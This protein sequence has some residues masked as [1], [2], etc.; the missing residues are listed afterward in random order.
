MK[1][2][3][4]TNSSRDSSLAT[5][6]G[7]LG[8]YEKLEN[9]VELDALNTAT[10]AEDIAEQWKK[11]I[12]NEQSVMREHYVRSL[13]KI[14]GYLLKYH[15][16]LD[17]MKQLESINRKNVSLAF[18]IKESLWETLSED[19]HKLSSLKFVEWKFLKI[20]ESYIKKYW[21]DVFNEMVRLVALFYKDRTMAAN[22][23][24]YILQSHNDNEETK[25]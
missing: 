5:L 12:E 15:G 21:K 18:R 16:A 3:E 24:E 2:L 6:L 7:L 13:S 14:Q 9:N 10:L 22:F 25:D 17:I 4:T 23:E 11:Y 19:G 20:K 1:I 8:L